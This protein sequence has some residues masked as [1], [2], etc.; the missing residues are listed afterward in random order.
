MPLIKHVAVL[1][2]YIYP[3]LVLG[4]C[5]ELLIFFEILNSTLL[6]NSNETETNNKKTAFLELNFVKNF[7]FL[8]F[9]IIIYIERNPE[10]LIPISFNY[11]TKSI[12]ISNIRGSRR[13]IKVS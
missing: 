3:F 10:N 1:S 9:K 12:S 4:H 7:F 11:A 13:Y 6:Q 2:R 8:N 5:I